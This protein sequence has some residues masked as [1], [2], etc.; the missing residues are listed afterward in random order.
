[1]LSFTQPLK[2][3]AEFEEI[4]KSMEKKAGNHTD[5]RLP[6]IPES[7]SHTWAFPKSSLASCDRRG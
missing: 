5:H 3:M 7:T 4:E 2:E 1:M 6:G